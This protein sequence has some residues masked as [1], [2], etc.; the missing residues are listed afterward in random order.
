MTAATATAPTK[1]TT[2]TAGT[3]KKATAPKVVKAVKPTTEATPKEKGGLTGNQLKA[4]GVLA[5][6][7]QPMTRSQL[8]A[9]TGIKKGWS[10]MLGQVTK[11]GGN[12]LEAAGLVKSMVADEGE[13][14]YRYIITAAGKK[15]VEKATAKRGK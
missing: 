9:K 15:A 11:G 10:K 7:T 5:K 12:G 1:A 14:G 2:K 4:L 13:R 8:A 6:A 3:T